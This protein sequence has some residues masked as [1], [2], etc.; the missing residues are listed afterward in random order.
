[1]VAD[2]ARVQG[3]VCLGYPFHPP[4]QPEKTRTAHLE[5]LATPAL[6]LQGTRDPFGQRGEVEAYRLSGRIRLHWVEDGDH[7]FKPRV[8]S[9]R[10]LEQNLEESMVAILDFAREIEAQRQRGEGP[11]VNPSSVTP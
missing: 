9:G 8:R 5:S 6:I 10:T 2:E 11:R 7:S 1:M 3:L 4:G